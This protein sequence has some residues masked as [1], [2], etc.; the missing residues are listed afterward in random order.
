M[1]DTPS[2]P[3]ATDRDVFISYASQDKPV[4]DAACAALE[5]AGVSCWIAPRD[6]TPGEFYAESIVHA[7]D[8]T[9]V[10]VLVL[11]KNAA[12][13]QHVIRE[14]ERA[15]SK[16]HPVVSLRIDAAP[17]PAGLE[18]FLNTSQ[19]LDAS[20][21]GVKVALPKLVD[22]VKSALAQ[23]SASMRA[24]PGPSATTRPSGRG[25]YAL[26]A[27]SVLVATALAYFAANKFWLTKHPSAEQPATIATP[28]A[29]ISDKSIAVLPFVDMSEKHDQ[30]YFSDGL[31]EELIDHLAH[32]TDLKVIARTS[33]FAFKGKN[34]DMRTIATKLGVANLP[35]GSVRKSGSTLR[36]TAQLIR[37]SDGVH[38]WS[39][40][41]DRKLNDIFKVQDEISTTVAKALNATLNVTTARD[42]QPASK[43]TT[44]VAAYNQVLQGNYFF[45]RNYSGDYARAIDHYQQALT[46]EPDYALALTKLA[47]V[48]IWQGYYGEITARDAELKAREAVQRALVTDPNYAR[49]YL[50]RASIFR[51]ILG[52]WSAA[53]SDYERAVAL[54]PHG[55][56]GEG[57]QEDSVYLKASMSGQYGDYINLM[58]RDLERNPLATGT[59]SDLAWTQQYAGK[60]DESAATSRRLLELN[61]SY[62]TA[63]AQ[64]ALTLLLMGKTSDALAAAEKE[65]DVALKLGTLAGIYWA[66]GRSAESNSALNNLEQ[67]FANRNEYG[68]AAIHAYRGEADAAMTWLDRAYQQRKGVL[69][70]V[71]ADHFFRNL[72]GDPRFKAF[73]RKMNLPE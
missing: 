13:S 10:I 21:L 25:R 6:V 14:V 60:L 4:A 62:S 71:K 9:Q 65:S 66:M 47:A 5:K 59:L 54:D 19:W 11:S 28:A 57:A 51:L 15:S 70:D 53:Q 42:A 69:Q 18:Y 26:I 20:A 7:I 68:I 32:I 1:T 41:Y 40:I 48:Y 37:A 73:L 33:S 3:A 52:D 61:P 23:P 46:L 55:Q 24:T 58:R 39:E 34:E 17:L 12:D 8:S 30:E 64:Y 16:R 31:S 72:H 38:R 56:I 22:A 44:N 50:I 45:A 29:A 2:N 49:A 36:I 63:Q 67:G 27:L 35:E 43:G